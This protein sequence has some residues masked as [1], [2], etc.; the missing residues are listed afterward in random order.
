MYPFVY[1]LYLDTLDT[2]LQVSAEEEVKRYLSDGYDPGKSLEEQAGALL[3]K[4]QHIFQ[5]EA[6]LQSGHAPASVEVARD[7]EIYLMDW[8]AEFPTSQGPGEEQAERAGR[9]IP[10]LV[11]QA[12]CPHFFTH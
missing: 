2:E 1:R 6:S 12:L 11:L 8:S 4:L 5:D 7:I 9:D 3:A 10:N